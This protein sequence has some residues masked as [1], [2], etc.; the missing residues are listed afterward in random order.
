MLQELNFGNLASGLVYFSGLG[1]TDRRAQ[2]SHDRY[3]PWKASSET[4]RKVFVT[5][6]DLFYG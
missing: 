4:S 5:A 2:W 3:A 1:K 6:L